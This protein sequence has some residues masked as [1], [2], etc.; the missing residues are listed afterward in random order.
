M[1]LFPYTTLFRSVGQQI[2]ECVA[3]LGDKAVAI[4]KQFE[5]DED[6]DGD[7]ESPAQP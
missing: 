2:K 4:L 3:E 6:E 5:G 7:E 1:T